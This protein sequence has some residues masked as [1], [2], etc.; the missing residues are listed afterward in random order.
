MPT[1][2]PPQPPNVPEPPADPQGFQYRL[3]RDEDRE[4]A[5]L[6][7]VHALEQEHFALSNNFTLR[8][9]AGAPQPGDDVTSEKGRQAQLARFRA[10]RKTQVE[11]ELAALHPRVDAVYERAKKNGRS[12]ME[13]ARIT[14]AEAP[15]QTADGRPISAITGRPVNISGKGQLPGG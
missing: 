12:I 11:A 9:V 7:K 6:I 5:I 2:R 10:E 15:L 3:L 8:G 4:E 1:E 14:S 13:E